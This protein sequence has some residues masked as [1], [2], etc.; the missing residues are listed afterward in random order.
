MLNDRQDDNTK[1]S[2]GKKVTCTSEFFLIAP[3]L[4]WTLTVDNELPAMPYAMAGST[5]Y[6]LTQRLACMGCSITR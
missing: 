3:T 1:G 4:G 5:A 6:S 2:Q